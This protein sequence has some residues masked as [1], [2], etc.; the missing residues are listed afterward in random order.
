M[1]HIPSQRTTHTITN[2]ICHCSVR[3]ITKLPDGLARPRNST[4]WFFEAV[5]AERKRVSYFRT[6]SSR[7]RGTLES[8]TGS[9][10]RFTATACLLCAAHKHTHATKIHLAAERRQRDRE[11]RS[12]QFCTPFVRFPHHATSSELITPTNTHIFAS[13]ARRFL[14]LLHFTCILC[15]CLATSSR[16]VIV[17]DGLFC[18]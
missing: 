11:F 5:T 3:V 15:C 6:R 18:F 17:R 14:R 7:D 12:S 2:T 9:S 10:S 8:P 1:I 16:Y 4:N 13:P